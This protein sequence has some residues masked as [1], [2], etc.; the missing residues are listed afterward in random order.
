MSSFDLRPL[1]LGEL[2]DRAFLLYRRNFALFAGIMVVPSCLTVPVQLYSLYVQGLPFHHVR[3]HH[4]FPG[5]NLVF[6]L[7]EWN[8]LAFAQAATT[9][10]V[11]DI[12]LG[13]D[14][15]I[16]KAYARS[17]R[18]FWAIVAVYWNVWLRTLG[19]I[20]LILVALLIAM[21]MV[22]GL[23]S[24]PVSGG[25]MSTGMFAVVTVIL[26]ASVLGAFVFC[27]RYSVALPAVL[28]EATPTQTGIR[29]SVVLTEDRRSHAFM[30]ILLGIVV[31]YVVAAVFQGPFYALMSIWKLNGLPSVLLAVSFATS[32]TAGT[33]LAAPAAMII[34]VLF[35]YDF[36]I[37]KE[38]FDLQH[39]MT[40][41]PETTPGAAV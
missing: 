8:L 34:P 23:A 39:M 14:T 29:R 1:S 6:M 22:I 13:C 33:I 16:A 9:Y 28:L 5:M 40:L 17:L 27:V 21:F 36:R 31:M 41:L 7:V 24:I 19:M 4:G 10:A 26:I 18:H 35:Y 37:R 20:A 2:L 38:A 30:G 12:Y 11:A 25:A 15:T 3:T 32:S